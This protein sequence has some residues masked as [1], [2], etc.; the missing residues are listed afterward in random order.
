MALTYLEQYCTDNALDIDQRT[1][2]LCHANM[3]FSR[4]H[5]D[6]TEMILISAQLFYFN[7]D[8]HESYRHLELYLDARL[9]ECKLSCHCCKQR[10]RHGYVP[11]SCASC[12]VASYCGTKHQKMTWK[13]ERI[14]HKVLCPLLGYWRIAKKRK[15][16]RESNG[17]GNEDRSEYV[18][19]FETFF[20]SICP[21]V[22][23][24]VIDCR[25][26]K[27]ILLLDCE[28]R[29]PSHLKEG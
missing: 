2:T 22:N 19:V 14:C 26:L 20:E 7:D 17:E 24:C 16:R 6:C 5:I 12:M 11:F 9:A 27:Q 1:E 28:G 21:H 13:N 4:R 23:K 15:T 8:K 25:K 18:R 10:V 29:L 3:Y